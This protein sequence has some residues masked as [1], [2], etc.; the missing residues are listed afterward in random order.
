[1]RDD[2]F[3]RVLL[4][5]K[6]ACTGLPF[7]SLLG[8]SHVRAC[9]RPVRLQ[10]MKDATGRDDARDAVVFDVTGYNLTTK[11]AE[12]LFADSGVPAPR[13]PSNATAKAAISIARTTPPKTA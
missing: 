11:E 4:S 5:F 13:V 7:P 6:I 3:A 1:M 12:Q 2:R 9:R 8:I 10:N